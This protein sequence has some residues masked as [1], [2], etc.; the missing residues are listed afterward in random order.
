MLF[1]LSSFF[2]REL[3]RLTKMN[4]NATFLTEVQD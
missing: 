1:P 3:M 2:L 4:T